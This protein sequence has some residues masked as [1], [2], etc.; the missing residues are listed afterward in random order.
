MEK[1]EDF[2]K[3][4]HQ[5]RQD[6]QLRGSEDLKADAKQLQAAKEALVENMKLQLEQTM[7]K[8]PK[9]E[10]KNFS[11]ENILKDLSTSVDEEFGKSFISSERIID[12]TTL[13][14]LPQSK[15]LEEQD[16]ETIKG[17]LPE[18]LKHKNVV[19]LYNYEK[20]GR[21]QSA[22]AERLKGW[23]WTFIVCKLSSGQV[24]GGFSDK[25]WS[26]YDG[27]F[28]SPNSFIF[29][30]ADKKKFLKRNAEGTLR[31]DQ[32]GIGFGEDLYFNRSAGTGTTAANKSYEFDSKDFNTTFTVDKLEIFGLSM[33]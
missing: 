1:H 22:M 26:G 23:K 11:I 24:Y 14:P 3:F 7:G 8:F 12:L 33:K 2:V 6:L 16:F 25:D 32:S 17:W 9:F 21:S 20:D 13:L 4:I 28:A 10:E 5:L 27:Y 31:F 18:N 29:N 30:L 19:L 15:C